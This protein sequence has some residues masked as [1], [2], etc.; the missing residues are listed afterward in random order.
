[1]SQIA[2]NEVLSKKSGLSTL[3]IGIL[4]KMALDHPDKSLYFG[5]M[6]MTVC[7]V[8]MILDFFKK[9][10]KGETA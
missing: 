6:V 10:K 5:G 9:N 3:T 7:I 4:T 1:M 8:Y 2:L